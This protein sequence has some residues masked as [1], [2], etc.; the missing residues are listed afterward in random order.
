MSSNFRYET[1]TLLLYLQ[2]SAFS[3][4][5]QKSVQNNVVV[6][7]Y[8]RKLKGTTLHLKTSSKKEKQ[9]ERKRLSEEVHHGTFLP[10]FEIHYFDSQDSSSSK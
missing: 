10:R 3:N 7:L 1:P 5:Q 4:S 9:T 2:A 8:Y 6:D